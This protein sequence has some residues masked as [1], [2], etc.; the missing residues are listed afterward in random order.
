MSQCPH[1]HHLSTTNRP[2][3]PNE[4]TERCQSPNLYKGGIRTLPFFNMKKDFYPTS[5]C[6]CCCCC[7]CCW[8]KGII[9]GRMSVCGYK[10]SA[11]MLPISHWSDNTL[12]LKSPDKSSRFPSIKCR[13]ALSGL[14]FAALCGVGLHVMSTPPQSLPH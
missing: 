3:L 13:S 11:Y 1:F 10:G 7:C 2:H 14:S 9:G 12:R 4:Y 8:R 6:C 5:S